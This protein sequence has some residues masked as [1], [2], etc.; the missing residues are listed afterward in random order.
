MGKEKALSSLGFFLG[1]IGIVIA[2]LPFFNMNPPQIYNILLPILLG[3]A[4]LF[5]VFKVKKVLNDNVVKVGSIVTPLAIVLGVIQ[6]VI[7]FIK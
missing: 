6:A 1:I 2:I 4:G 3:A 7:Y 5:L